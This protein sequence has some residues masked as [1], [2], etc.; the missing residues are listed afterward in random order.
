MWR[1]LLYNNEIIS[2]FLPPIVFLPLWFLILIQSSSQ[3]MAERRVGESEDKESS[4]S[5]EVSMK[6]GG[7]KKRGNYEGGRGDTI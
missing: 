6:K 4:D 5:E 2:Y 1:A 7:G 3:G